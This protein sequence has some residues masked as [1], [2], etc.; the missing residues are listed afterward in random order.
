[1]LHFLRVLV[2]FEVTLKFISIHKGRLVVLEFFLESEK[3]SNCV[4]VEIF[5][6]TRSF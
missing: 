2:T 4:V 1:M 5:E 3:L 6:F